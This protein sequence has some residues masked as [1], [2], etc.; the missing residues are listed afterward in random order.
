MKR[1][2]SRPSM[3]RRD[4]L[5][6][7]L[8]AFAAQE[9]QDERLAP[10]AAEGAEEPSLEETMDA[11]LGDLRVSG[12]RLVMAL[13]VG[14][15][16]YA[17]LRWLRAQ[18]QRLSLSKPQRVMAKRALP[19]A[20]ALLAV[21]YVVW[22]LR[23]VLAGHPL[24]QVLLLGLLV[25]AFIFVSWLAIRDVVAGMAFRASEV[26]AP[27]DIIEADGISGRISSLGYRVIALDTPDGSQAFIPYGRVAQGAIVRKPA[28]DGLHRHV[29]EAALPLGMPVVEARRAIRRH[30]LNS[31]WHSVVREPQVRLRDKGVFVVTVFSVAPNLGHRIEAEVLRGLEGE[32]T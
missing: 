31:H 1:V 17:A 7:P 15:G 18:L 5:R 14:V 4:L 19:L 24:H 22:A 29:F 11:L 30:A 27:G 9:A 8:E 16:L 21:V 2:I 25:P 12:A 26:C 20:E 32:G 3:T 23:W 13:L 10:Q 28:T 6:A